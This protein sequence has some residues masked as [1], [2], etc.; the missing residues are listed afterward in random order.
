MDMT[1][2]IRPK[3]DQLDADELLSGPRTFTI[4]EVRKGPSDEQ[5]F[6]FILAEHPRPWRPC[7]TVRKLIVAAWGPETTVCHGRRLTLVRDPSVTWAGEAVG[8]IRVSHMSHLKDSKPLRVSVQATSKTKTAILIQP[9]SDAAPPPDY[10]AQ[11]TTA[12]SKQDLNRVW[13]AAKD[14]GHLNQQIMDALAARGAQLDAEITD[15]PAD[16]GDQA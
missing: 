2:S 11:I 3:S 5:P 9:L 15:D 10:A 1:E 16:G 4:T 12:A 14:A 8:G 7:K 13:Q 6:D